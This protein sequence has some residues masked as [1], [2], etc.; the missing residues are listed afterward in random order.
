VFPVHPRLRSRLASPPRAPA[1][2]LI[3][4][5]GYIDFL[6]LQLRAVAVITDSGGVQEETTYLRVPCFTLRESTERPITV[7]QGTNRLLGLDVEAVETIPRLLEQ[8]PLL[9]APP[10][11]WDGCAAERIADALLT[12]VGE[13]TEYL[14]TAVDARGG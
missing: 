3:D 2:A 1:L 4:P 14:P 5:I 12:A 6:A 13:T 8:M 11:L 7:T 9:L 10:P